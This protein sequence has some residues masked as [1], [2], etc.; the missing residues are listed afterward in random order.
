MNLGETGRRGELFVPGGLVEIW[1]SI[2]NLGEAGSRGVL[3]VPG[4]LV[5]IRRSISG[6]RSSRSSNEECKNER[7][8]F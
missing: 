1:R 8:H 3:L 7:F 2:M 5:E 6:S 4:R